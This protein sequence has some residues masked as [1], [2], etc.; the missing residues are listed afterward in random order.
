MLNVLT[1]AK[2]KQKKLVTLPNFMIDR[3]DEYRNRVLMYP[4]C[5]L[6]S[7][8]SEGNSVHGRGEISTCLTLTTLT[9]GSVV[10]GTPVLLSLSTVC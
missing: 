10:A 8:D 5:K 1:E 3:D 6:N 4:Y 9:V 2:A 7:C